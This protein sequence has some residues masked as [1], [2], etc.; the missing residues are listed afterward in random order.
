MK[1]KQ[2]DSSTYVKERIRNDQSNLSEEGRG[3]GRGYG[4]AGYLALTLER[5]TNTR[6]LVAMYVDDYHDDSL[7]LLGAPGVDT[8]DID[9][10]RR[11][12]KQ[13]PAYYKHGQIRSYQ[14]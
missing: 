8:T 7:S 6:S 4:H 13:R 9:Y 1:G 11:Q 3:G 12:Y 2:I 14:C 5:I 10:N